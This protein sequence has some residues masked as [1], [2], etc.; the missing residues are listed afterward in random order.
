M[1][2]ESLISPKKAER[3]PW[4]MVFYG[5]LYSSIAIVL[6]LWVFKNQAALIMVFL[7]VFACIPLMYKTIRLEEKKESRF[8][9]EMKLLKEHWKALYFFM[10]L[11]L[12]FVI[13]FS[14]WYIF[15]PPSWI[16][17]LF[18]VQVETI[19]EINSQ[20]TGNATSMNALLHILSNNFRVLLFSVF[21]S[22]F[23]GAGAIF[24]LT[25]NASVI[26]SAIGSFVRTKVSEYTLNIGLSN[27][28]SYFY[29]FQFGAC[30][31]LRYLTH[32][33]FEIFAYFMG[34]LAGGIISVAVIRH[35]I[36]TDKF[37]QIV[38]DSLDLVVIAALVLVVAAFIEVYVT[39]GFISTACGV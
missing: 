5:M 2:L 14:L 34:G 17:S 19:R 25:W 39:P 6:S 11:F 7:T 29:L 13:S 16:D 21:F 26:S 38:T 15:S 1:V 18:S 30:G 23:Y 10:T 24:I 9:S 35:D 8:R 33:V 4:E 31:F 28:S 20:I 27:A 12:G 37:K 22:F 32:G 3:K 36:Y